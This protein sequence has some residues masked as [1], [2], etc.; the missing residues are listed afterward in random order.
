[1]STILGYVGDIFSAMFG[2]TGYISQVITLVT[3]N[4]YLMVGL[5][6]MISGAVVSYLARLIRNT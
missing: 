4:A 6:L 3:G 5:S 1:M 2:T